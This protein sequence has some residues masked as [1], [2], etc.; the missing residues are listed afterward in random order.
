MD[1]GTEL[2]VVDKMGRTARVIG[3]YPRMYAD[4]VAYL[5]D[6]TLKFE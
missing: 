3:I 6:N 5:I 4:G 2:Q 1:T